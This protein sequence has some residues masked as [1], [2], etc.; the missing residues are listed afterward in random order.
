MVGNQLLIQYI[1]V[2]YTGGLCQMENLS[3]RALKFGIGVALLCWRSKFVNTRAQISGSTVDWHTSRSVFLLC[4]HCFKMGS[5]PLWPGYSYWRWI[6]G[7]ITHFTRNKIQQKHFL[8]TIISYEIRLVVITLV[9]GGATKIWRNN[10]IY[11]SINNLP[12]ESYNDK[13]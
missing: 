10:A 6:N 4:V 5:D 11:D 12:I 13:W 8:V 3:V 7:F 9:I 1:R 2:R